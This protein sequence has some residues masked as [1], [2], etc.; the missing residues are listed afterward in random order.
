MTKDEMLA[1]RGRWADGNYDEA[2]L[3]AEPPVREW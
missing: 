1:M 2:A 3:T